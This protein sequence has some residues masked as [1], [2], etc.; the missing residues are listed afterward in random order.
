M[1]D[2]KFKIASFAKNLRLCVIENSIFI[3]ELASRVLGNILS[4]DYEKSKS[5]G[6]ASTSL[7]FNQ[8]LQLIQDIKGIEKEDLK[9]LTCL[10]NIRNKFAHVSNI[11]TFEKLFSESSVG[12]DIRRCFL[13]WFFDTNGDSDIHTSKVEFVYRVCFYLLVNDIIEILLKIND[14]HSYNI[15]LHEGQKE[16]KDKFVDTIIKSLITQKQHLAVLE[17]IEETKRLMNSES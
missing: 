8:K 13:N 5:F 3:E 6:H 15:G 10:A 11:D 1:S 14:T 12:K 9:K 16:F 17:A 2:E 7:S 4:I